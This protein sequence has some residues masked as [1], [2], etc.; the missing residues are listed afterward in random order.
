MSNDVAFSY[1][2][3]SFLTEHAGRPLVKGNE[4][5]GYQGD[6]VNFI[7]VP[8]DRVPFG[9]H[10]E[11]QPLGGSNCRNMRIVIVSHS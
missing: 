7:L 8:K 4:D 1:L 10:Q 3:S 9:Q 2:E 5:T 6:D 11:S